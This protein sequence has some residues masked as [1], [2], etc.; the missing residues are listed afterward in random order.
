M[1]AKVTIRHPLVVYKNA[2]STCQD[3]FLC[4][5]SNNQ[6]IKKFTL[7]SLFHPDKRSSPE[8]ETFI[9]QIP[10]RG[11]HQPVWFVWIY[12]LGWSSRGPHSNRWFTPSIQR[13]TCQRTLR[14]SRSLGTN[15]W[16]PELF[17]TAIKRHGGMSRGFT[18]QHSCILEG[19]AGPADWQHRSWERAA[20]KK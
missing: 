20:D 7:H 15:N 11:G 19:C 4:T 10:Q 3:Q 5:A 18:V 1:G 6:K 16:M 17:L 14:C 12:F 2:P 9:I 13:W 8:I